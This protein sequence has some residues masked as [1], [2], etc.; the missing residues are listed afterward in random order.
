MKLSFLFNEMH[1]R[2]VSVVFSP[3][4]LL[5]MLTVHWYILPSSVSESLETNVSN[6]ADNMYMYVCSHPYSFLQLFFII[7]YIFPKTLT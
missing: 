3:M 7:L 1:G 2:F 5:N 6:K 4:F